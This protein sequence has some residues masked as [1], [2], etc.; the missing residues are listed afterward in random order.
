MTILWLKLRRSL[1]GKRVLRASCA[2]LC[3]C[4]PDGSCL[5]ESYAMSGLILLVRGSSP[6]QEALIGCAQR[7]SECELQRKDDV[8]CSGFL[9]E[10]VAG[11]GVRKCG[12]SRVRAQL[13]AF[14]S[15]LLCPRIPL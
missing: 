1:S 13:L 11:Q 9:P 7:E 10:V 14:A 15:C 6:T 12:P 3:V 5:T 4:L 2:C 8:E